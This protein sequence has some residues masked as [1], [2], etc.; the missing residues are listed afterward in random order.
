M[1]GSL[2]NIQVILACIYAP[3][4]DDASFVSRLISVLPN[5]NSHRLIFGDDINCVMDLTLDRSSSKSVS[6]SKMAHGCIDP[7]HFLFPCN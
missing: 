7:R 5:R 4:W 3:N 1:T 6:P 2:F